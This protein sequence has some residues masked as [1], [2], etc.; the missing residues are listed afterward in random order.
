MADLAFWEAALLLLLEFLHVFLM[1]GGINEESG[2]RG[3][4]LPRLQSGP[5]YNGRY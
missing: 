4:A 3:F 2:W 5:V 1:T